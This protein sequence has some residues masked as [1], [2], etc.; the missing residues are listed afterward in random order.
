MKATLWPTELLRHVLNRS[1]PAWLMR[2][3]S[4]L[5]KESR[6]FCKTSIVH[7]FVATTGL[8]P[9]TFPI[10]G[11]ALP[12]ELHRIPKALS[13]VMLLVTALQRQLFYWAENRSR[14]GDLN[15]GK[16]TLYQLSYFRNLQCPATEHFT[17]SVASQLR[18]FWFIKMS[19]NAANF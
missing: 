10:A 19:N 1:R 13:M 7:I 4:S 11:D 17:T 16:V 18:F 8:E 3:T 2:F 15:L 6:I 5:Q 14:T 12:T 9:M